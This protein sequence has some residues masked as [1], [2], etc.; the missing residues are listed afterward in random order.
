M[1][2]HR[3]KEATSVF[4]LGDVTVPV[5]AVKATLKET[6][7]AIKDIVAVDIETRDP[8][9]NPT[10]YAK[11]LVDAFHEADLHLKNRNNKEKYVYLVIKVSK[12]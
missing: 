4:D 10:F 8:E 11:D 2:M 6:E 7:E 12:S 5:F 9:E 3:M 1:A